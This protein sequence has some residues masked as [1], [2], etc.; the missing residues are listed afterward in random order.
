MLLRHATPRRNLPSIKRGGL[1]TAK[2]LGRMPAV[3]LHAPAR[4]APDDPAE[5][6]VEHHRVQLG[7]VRRRDDREWRLSL[8]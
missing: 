4:G 1:L 2:S 6:R 7:T 8:D 3:W 5:P